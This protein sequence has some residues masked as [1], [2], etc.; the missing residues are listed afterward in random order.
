MAEATWKFAPEVDAA[1][2]EALAAAFAQPDRLRPLPGAPERLAA[3]RRY[4][5]LACPRPLPF[6]VFAKVFSEDSPGRR[7]RL[8]LGRSDAACEFR[9]A[10]GLRQAGLPVPRPLALVVERPASGPPQSCLLMEFIADARPLLDLLAGPPV[11]VGQ[12]EQ[13]IAERLARLI[14]DL[15]A[16]G[17]WHKDLRPANILVRPHVA[18]GTPSIVLLDVRHAVA[19]ACPPEQALGHMLAA[20]CGFLLAEGA[21]AAFVRALAESAVR[22]GCEVGMGLAPQAAEAA[23]DRGRAFAR[24]LAA[25]AAR[26]DAARPDRPAVPH[27]ALDTFA[28]RYG[29]A[30]DAASYRD[31]R[32]ARSRHGRKVDAAERRIV[33]QLMR[34][35]AVRGRVLDVPCGAGRFLPIL[36][37]GGRD[38]LGADAAPEMIDLARRAAHDA[39]AGAGCSFVAADARR[40]PVPDGATEFVLCMRLLH[41]IADAAERAAVLKELARVSRRWVLFSF[42]NS[43]S[44][45]GLRERLRGRYA[46]ETRR[47]VAREAAEAGLAVERFLPAGPGGRQTLVL[48]SAAHPER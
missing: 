46:G 17:F 23:L 6:Q 37:A 20:A 25:R 12:A 10:V 39:G 30:A 24:D 41:R 9:I 36:A 2:R 45:R 48:C 40:L 47:T 13:A 7:L 43:R 11:A 16:R 1:A 8:L 18:G 31:R 22:I 14:V 5:L 34:D 26:K 35:L 42:Y 44:L 15:A 28:H 4:G 21:D 19:G 32:F 29:S 27:G 3:R 33:E 38:V